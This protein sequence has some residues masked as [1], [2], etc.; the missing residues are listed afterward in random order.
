MQSWIMFT[1]YLL[2]HLNALVETAEEAKKFL[3][4]FK[5]DSFQ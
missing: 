5:K 1:Y 3:D 4:G 2:L